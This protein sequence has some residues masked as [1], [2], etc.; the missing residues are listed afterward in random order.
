MCNNISCAWNLSKG[1]LSFTYLGVPLFKNRPK[2]EFLLP[3][4][5]RIKSKLAS[6]KGKALSMAGRLTLI[7]SVIS[8]SFTHAFFSYKWTKNIISY[9]N[10]C[11]RNLLWAGSI[12][13]RKLVTVSW[14]KVY[15]PLSE[16]GLGIKDLTI[17]NLAFLKKMTWDTN[18]IQK[19]LRDILTTQNFSKLYCCQSC[20]FFMRK[21]EKLGFV[22]FA[23]IFF[24]FLRSFFNVRPLGRRS[25]CS[26]HD[27]SLS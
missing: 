12:I 15:K 20:S 2:K 8:G 16:G 24:F 3:I 14:H 27:G 9:L 18:F 19:R 6:W 17:S 25:F 21:D 1:F 7:K 13:E 4:I 26:F 10:A 11:I 5:D 22:G 23:Q